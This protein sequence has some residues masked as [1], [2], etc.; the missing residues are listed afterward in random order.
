MPEALYTLGRLVV[1][2]ALMSLGFWLKRIVQQRNGNLTGDAFL[3][4]QPGWRQ[5][6]RRYESKQVIPNTE[7]L[8]IGRIGNVRFTGVLDIGFEVNAVILCNRFG[9]S[10][11]AVRI[12]YAD[13]ELLQAP[14]QF[15][16]TRFNDPEFSPGSFRVAGVEIEL[17]AYWADQLLKHMA[18]SPVA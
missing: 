10:S 12:P 3:P 13:L 15:Q 14:E 17:P 1:L 6:R 5:L 9:F 11:A 18:A 16:A 4:P 2:G 8:T 7:T